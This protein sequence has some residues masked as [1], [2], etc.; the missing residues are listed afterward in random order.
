MRFLLSIT[1]EISLQSLAFE[2]IF[3]LQWY[4]FQSTTFHCISMKRMIYFLPIPDISFV[5][6][7]WIYHECLRV[8]NIRDFFNS[9]NKTANSFSNKLHV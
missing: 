5:L 1:V 2:P 4:L 6:H 9:A 8:R 3:K 7:I